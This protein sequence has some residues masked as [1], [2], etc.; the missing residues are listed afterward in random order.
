MP[1]LLKWLSIFNNDPVRSQV[2]TLRGELDGLT[3]A[4]TTIALAQC[5]ADKR[6]E[7]AK[8][9]E[10]C[11]SVHETHMNR[12]DSYDHGMLLALRLAIVASKQS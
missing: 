3:L 1:K 12:D 4:L 5:A 10:S 11:L 7:I 8:L 2:R 9:L 6:D